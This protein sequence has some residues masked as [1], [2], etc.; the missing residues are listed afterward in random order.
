MG[1]PRIIEMRK[2]ILRNQLLNYLRTMP[3]WHKK[4]SLFLVADQL[5]YSPE[6]CGRRLRELADEGLI[7]AGYYNGTHAKN[8]T[9]YTADEI[10][11]SNENPNI[12]VVEI[13]GERKAI[14][15]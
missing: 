5:G 14:M 11:R 6:T 1:K 8:L 7:K 15:K 4:V 12:T 3:G 2:T 13:N 9:K 10:P